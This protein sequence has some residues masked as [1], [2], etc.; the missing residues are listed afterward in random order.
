MSQNVFR[1]VV[2]LLLLAAARVAAAEPPGE[3]AAHSPLVWLPSDLD[4][5]LDRAGAVRQYRFT[6]DRESLGIR[7]YPRARRHV[8]LE[9]LLQIADRVASPRRERPW[10][11]RLHLHR[12]PA[13]YV[14]AL[15]DRELRGVRDFRYRLHLGPI[16]SSPAFFPPAAGAASE[17]EVRL[18]GVFLDTDRV[19]IKIPAEPKVGDRVPVPVSSQAF[20]T[21]LGVGA[22]VVGEFPEV[23]R[24]PA[25]ARCPV[26]GTANGAWLRTASAD[27]WRFSREAR[28]NRCSS[29]RMPAGSAR[30]SIRCSRSSTPRQ[31]GAAGGAALPGED[32]RHL[33]RPRLGRAGHPPRGVERAGHQRLP[34]TSAAS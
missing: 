27:V 31:A 16:P 12:K 2:A 10:L 3:S 7:V 24:P 28:A 1:P 14:L 18:K 22:V 6:V 26:P 17:T 21:P 33:P 15:R 20:G 4:G 9:P 34:A 29:R 32:L 13:R 25:Q 30:R 8:E 19:R 23:T 11:S 5:G